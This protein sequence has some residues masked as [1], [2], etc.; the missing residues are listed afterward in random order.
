M[1]GDSKNIIDE[2]QEEHRQPRKLSVAS[3]ED[4]NAARHG[5]RALALMYDIAPRPSEAYIADGTSSQWR[6]ASELDRG[7]CGRS[8]EAAILFHQLTTHRIGA[9]AARRTES[10]SQYSS[11]YH[12]PG[13]K[14]SLLTETVADFSSFA[15]TGLLPT[16]G[17]DATIHSPA[18]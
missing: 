10:Y 4:V 8:H 3:A 12:T 7:R 13:Q 11:G 6:R 9:Y 2:V 1:T 15:S 14:P 16:G 17:L 18:R 5:D